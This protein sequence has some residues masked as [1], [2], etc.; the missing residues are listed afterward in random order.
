MIA[1]SSFKSFVT[2]ISQTLALICFA[3]IGALSISSVCPDL[4]SSLFH[5]GEGCSHA[6]SQDPCGS[7]NKPSNQNDEEDTSCAVVLFGLGLEIQTHFH[8]S[9]FN[10]LSSNVEF[11]SVH[12]IWTTCKYA[13][14]G[15]RDPPVF[16]SV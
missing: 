2:R 5:G 11:S 14:F 7:G 4:H 6:S 8:I 13:P 1:L 10:G 3:L 12:L 15:A 16:E 9:T